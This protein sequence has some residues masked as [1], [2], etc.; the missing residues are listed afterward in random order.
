MTAMTTPYRTPDPDE[1]GLSPE[2]ILIGCRIGAIAQGYAEITHAAGERA[3]RAGWREYL[4][5]RMAELEAE[6]PGM[7]EEVRSRVVAMQQHSNRA[8]AFAGQ[9]G[10]A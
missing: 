10:V 9:E 8:R 6:I 4:A 3:I 5:Q 2:E 7:S 1:T